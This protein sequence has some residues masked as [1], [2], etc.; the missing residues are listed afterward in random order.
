M[1]VGDIFYTDADEAL[2]L[3]SD[4]AD[5]LG[6]HIWKGMTGGDYRVISVDYLSK[7][8]KN[9]NDLTGIVDGNGAFWTFHD[10]WTEPLQATADR[11]NKDYRGANPHRVAVFTF[12][13]WA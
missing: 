12:K 6:R 5:E 7:M 2:E 3:V 1:K 9:P 11:W 10:G 13:E 8:P 4:T